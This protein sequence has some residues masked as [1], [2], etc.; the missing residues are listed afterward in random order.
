MNQ[1]PHSKQKIEMNNILETINMNKSFY[2]FIFI[3]SFSPDLF[4]FSLKFL[5]VK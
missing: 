5:V 1:I 4:D 2:T 3:S